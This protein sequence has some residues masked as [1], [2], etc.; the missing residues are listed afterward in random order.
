MGKSFTRRE[1]LAL[2]ATAGAAGI[3]G[4]ARSDSQG[5]SSGS[6]AAS[7]PTTEAADVDLGEFSSLAIDMKS[8]SY[9]EDHDIYWQVG[10]PYCR[11]PVSEMYETLAIYVPGRYFEAKEHGRFYSCT[12]KRGVEVGRFASTGAPLVIPINSVEF[13][14]QDAPT[15]YSYE[16]DLGTYLSLGMIVVYPGLRGRSSSYDSATDTYMP[17]GAPLGLVDLKAVVRYLRYN[18]ADMPGSANRIVTIGHGSGGTLSVLA[19]ATGDSA[20]F[21]PY[22]EEIGAATHDAEGKTLSDAVW[23]SVSWCPVIPTS[24]GDAA[25]EWAVGQ[26]DDSVKRRSDSFGRQLSR[27]LAA[28]WAEHVGEMELTDANGN[29]L[30]LEETEGADDES[31]ADSLPVCCAGSYYNS[32]VG[33]LEHAFADFATRCSFPFTED[34]S[35]Q[36]SGRFP[37]AGD[38]SYGD[39]AESLSTSSATGT[40]E[41]DETA[42]EETGVTFETLEDYIDHLNVD[43][44]WLAYDVGTGNATISSLGAFARACRPAQKEL[45]AFDA[46]DRSAASNQLFG[47]GEEMESLHFDGALSDLLNQNADTYEDLSG[48]DEDYPDE[49]DDDLDQADDLGTSIQTR[50]DMYDPFY[51]VAPAGDGAGTSSVAPHW[52]ISS[53]VQQ[54]STTLV[55]E[56]DLA[57]CLSSHEGVL[58]SDLSLVWESG[59]APAERVGDLV[60]NLAAWI[61]GCYQK[62]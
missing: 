7:E 4:C 37:G 39:D 62:R 9:D 6:D 51:F 17:G 31:A 48:W 10:I 32:V 15:A 25:Y 22:L 12:V 23:A 24:D 27:D 5:G 11:D 53:G 52:R 28:R 55:Q 35:S 26:Y 45:G 58:T 14:S 41:G 47:V 57:C 46:L 1:F 8:W 20:L 13:A 34:L 42:E 50:C 61:A 18:D 2:A 30:T 3:A 29:A 40:A 54:D 36:P 19:G 21:D 16:D 59:Y 44:Q 56:M 33:K 49:F 43:E 60:D 38:A